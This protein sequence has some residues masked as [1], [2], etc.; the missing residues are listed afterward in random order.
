MT[1]NHSWGYNKG[2]DDWKSLR[3]CVEYLVT[4]AGGGGNYLLNI[5]PKADG[6]IPPQSVRALKGVGDWLSRNG[7]AI[8]GSDRAQMEMMF[9]IWG[10][11]TRKGRTAYLHVFAWPGAEIAI[12]G[13]RTKVTSARLLATGEDVKFSQKG[14]RLVLSGLPE[15]K[16]DN[17][18]A[19]IALEC[20][21][22]PRQ[23]LGHGY[24]LA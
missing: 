18:A 19:V 7:E 6:S 23:R 13:L 11:W 12:G 4:A 24:V 10:R 21:G 8:Y 22:A 2:D 1:M 14:N 3:T 5:G 15:K 17:P 9:N 16:P 20:A